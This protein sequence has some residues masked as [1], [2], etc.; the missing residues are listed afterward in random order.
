MK[1]CFFVFVLTALGIATSMAGIDI[2]AAEGFGRITLP[3]GRPAIQFEAAAPMDTAAKWNLPAPLEPGW[4][5][6]ELGWGPDANTRKLVSME[7]LDAAG[8]PVLSV[9]LYNAPGSKA[10]AASPV[11]GVFLSRPAVAVRWRKNQTRAVLSTPI[12]S[13]SIK[14]GRPAAGSAFLEAVETP[15]VSGIAQFPKDLGGGLL[16]AVSLSPL[17]LKWTLANGKSFATPAATATSVFLDGNLSG[18]SADGS[19]NGSLCLEHRFESKS[20]VDDRLLSHPVIPLVGPGKQV[21]TIDVRGTGLDGRTATLA[22]FPG[23]ARMAAVQSWDDGIPNDKRLAELLRKTGWRASFFFN[24]NSPMLER[25]KELE[26]LEMEVGSHSWSHPFYW[27]QTPRRCRE[28]SLGMRLLLESKTGHPVISFAYPFNY[29]AAYDALGDYVLRA[30]EEA[31]YLSGRSTNVGVLSLDDLGNPLT[32]KTDGHF[33]LPR[34]RIEAA[35][36]GA[37]ATKRGV[38][39]MWGHS[40]ELPKE[41]DWAAFEDLL[42]K[43]GRRPE[44]WYASQGD[45][46]VWKWLRANVSL[47]ATGDSTHAVIRLEREALHPWWAARVPV[48][49]QMPGQITQATANG[50]ALP[51]VN[52]QIQV[53]WPK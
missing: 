43:F 42:G 13:L 49:I 18:L 31:G 34:D 22:D 50:K 28:E 47:S 14:P 53:A 27:L 33:L 26:D 44:A 39:Y 45:L 35:W 41:T 21:L 40:Y 20:P 2:N 48:A 10:Q 24:R 36:N 9:D 16:R 19:V 25:W 23:G 8:N 52:G 38:F 11:M 4:Y 29:G 30:Q 46:L 12:A 6:V 1:S 3:D 51:V 5:S 15:V 37:A 7:W 17:V 32:M